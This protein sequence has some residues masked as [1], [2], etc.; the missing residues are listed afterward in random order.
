MNLYVEDAGHSLQ[1]EPHPRTGANTLT[2]NSFPQTRVASMQY[3]I[4]P[5]CHMTC[6]AYLN[7]AESI[8]VKREAATE[9]SRINMAQRARIIETKKACGFYD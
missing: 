8:R 6:E 9:V 2:K 1:P 3:V 5:N 7:W 4:A